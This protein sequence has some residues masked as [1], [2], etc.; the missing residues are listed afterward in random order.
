MTEILRIV[1]GDLRSLE[2][3]VATQVAALARPLSVSWYTLWYTC[4]PPLHG[5]VLRVATAD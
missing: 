5:A 4:R 2:A 3:R 1:D